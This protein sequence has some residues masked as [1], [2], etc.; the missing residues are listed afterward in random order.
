MQTTKRLY[1]ILYP[2]LYEHNVRHDE[3][4]ALLWGAQKGE[5][6]L[7]DKLLAAGANIAAYVPPTR[8]VER[9]VRNRRDIDPWAKKNPLLYAAQGEHTQVLNMLLGETRSGQAASPAQLRS[10]LHWALRQQ[11]GQLVELMLAH[12][13]PLDPAT[14]SSGAP[15]ALGVAMA[16]GY[17][18]ILPRLLALGA[19]PGTEETPSPTQLAICANHPHIVRLFLDRGWGLNSDEALSHIAHENDRAM[20]RLLIEYGLN[21]QACSPVPLFT[22]I[23]DGHYEMTELLIDNGII[24]D[25]TCELYPRSGWPWGSEYSAVGFAILYERLD[26]L[27]LLLDKGFPPEERDLKLATERNFVQAISLLKPFAERELRMLMSIGN[28]LLWG[29]DYDLENSRP[30]NLGMWQMRCHAQ[31]IIDTSGTREPDPEDPFDGRVACGPSLWDS[32]GDHS[33]ELDE[34]YRQNPRT[35]YFL[36]S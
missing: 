27:K 10:V 4:S 9:K 18:A 21:L 7:V 20:L 16:A 35:D 14:K 1:H 26:I 24:K 19:R 12:Q 29:F 25:L 30:R 34:Y 11:D 13:A 2:L 8:Y 28:Q 36:V 15:S 31:G 17:T 6:R 23:R 22:A 32:D 5:A 3:S 33:S